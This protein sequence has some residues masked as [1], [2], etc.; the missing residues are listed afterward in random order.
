[1]LKKKQTTASKSG[2][3]STVVASATPNAVDR[4]GFLRGRCLVV[5]A[6]SRPIRALCVCIRTRIDRADGRPARM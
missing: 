2:H 5:V 1:M 4:R 6:L 3:G